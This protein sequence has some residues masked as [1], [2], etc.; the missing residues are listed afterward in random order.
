MSWLGLL[1]L[2]TSLFTLAGGVKAVLYQKAVYRKSRGIFRVESTHLTGS[3]A[4]VLGVVYLISGV[5]MLAW[6]CVFLLEQD[7]PLLLL[8]LLAALTVLMVAADWIIRK[9]FLTDPF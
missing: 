6:A 9:K 4:I 3:A 8:W 2:I 5:L 1:L 7:S